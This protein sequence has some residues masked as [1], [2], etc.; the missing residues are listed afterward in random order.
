M[1]GNPIVTFKPY[2]LEKALENQYEQALEKN[3]S[4]LKDIQKRMPEFKNDLGWF[5]IDEWANQ[6]MVQELM[7]LAKE[8]RERAEVF[9]LIGVGGSNNAARSVIEALQ[10]F[11]DSI[12]IIYSGNNL[13]AREMQRVL[14]KIQGKSCYIHC[15]AK[16]FETLEPGV[17]FRILRN[18]LNEQYSPEEAARRIICTGTLGS[19]FETFCRENNYRFLAFPTNIGGRYTAISS[20]GLFPMAVA[21][22]DI[23]QVVAGAKQMQIQ[24]A[25]ATAGSNVAYHYA[26]YRHLLYQSDFRIEML[27]SFESQFRYFNKWWLQLFAESEGKEQSGL[28]PTYAE[29]SEDLHAVGQYVQEGHP[30]LIETF[31]SVKEPESTYTIPKTIQVDGFEY[32]SGKDLEELNAAAYQATVTAHQT[33]LNTAIIEINRLDASSFGQLF[34]FFQYACYVSCCLNDVHPFNQ[35]GVELYKTHL[36]KSLGK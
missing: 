15:I 3:A 5:E 2:F 32:V 34:Y 23:S 9:V 11:D 29:Y 17:S 26:V 21:G 19:S 1:E 13:S 33:R 16:N 30:Q 35:P 20:V 18:Y 25:Q 14:H 28:Y 8:I 10:A 12:E 6:A 4:L 27:A 36:F 24:L 7:T 22:I 31:L